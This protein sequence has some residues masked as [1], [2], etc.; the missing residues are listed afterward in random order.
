MTRTECAESLIALF[1]EYYAMAR[2]YG[3]HIEA[4]YIEAVA[5]AIIALGERRNDG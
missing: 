5:L 2:K 1:S 4:E 3:V